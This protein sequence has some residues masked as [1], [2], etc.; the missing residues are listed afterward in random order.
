MNA[1]QSTVS[2]EKARPTWHVPRGEGQEGH[3]PLPRAQR[4]PRP[5]EAWG[6]VGTDP[7][8]LALNS[9]GDPTVTGAGAR[10]GTM[11]S[12]FSGIFV[13]LWEGPGSLSGPQGSL[14]C[15]WDAMHVSPPPGSPPCW[16]WP[17][18]IPPRPW[19]LSGNGSFPLVEKSKN[20]HRQAPLGLLAAGT[21]RPQMCADDVMD[22]RQTGAWGATKQGPP[23]SN[24]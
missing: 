3:C 9:L 13:I 4:H 12:P 5:G 8:G 21:E 11:A 10:W 15:C 7:S 17:P 20:H 16:H 23:T 22:D 6:V 24:Q 18:W 19:P 1:P 14:L 2:P